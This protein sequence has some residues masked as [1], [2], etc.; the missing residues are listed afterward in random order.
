MPTETLLP[1]ASLEATGFA[2]YALADVDEDPDAP[3]ANWA[4][5]SSNNNATSNRVSFPTP[6]GNPTGVQT[7][8]IYVRKFSGTQSGTPLARIDLYE[9]GTLLASGADQSVTSATGQMLSQD[10][11]LA[12]T[13]LATSDGSLVE[14]R[15]VG[16]ASG[17]SPGA[18]NST[19]LGAINW[20]IVNYSAGGTPYTV[21]P[22]DAFGLTDQATPTLTPGGGEP[23]LPRAITLIL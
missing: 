14:A 5:A 19:D 16:T 20:D 18:R 21:T 10:F 8:K 4:V 11:D 1:D 3:D 23:P 13:P 15:F 2:S 6:T 17:G 12:T 22:A 7:F 9:N